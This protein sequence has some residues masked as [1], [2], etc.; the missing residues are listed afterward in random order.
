MPVVY[1]LCFTAC[2]QMAGYNGVAS[3]APEGHARGQAL[4]RHGQDRFRREGRR[5]V[6]SRLLDHL[7]LGKNG[8]VFVFIFHMYDKAMMICQDR[9]GTN[10][11]MR[12]R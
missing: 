11:L 10:L 1:M 7:R 4:C 2:I 6:D 8:A 9:L 5:H 3:N 12:K